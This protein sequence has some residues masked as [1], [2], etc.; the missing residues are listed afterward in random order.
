MSMVYLSQNDRI[1]YPKAAFHP[2]CAYPEYPFGGEAISK[3][4][5]VVYEAVRNCL[6]GLGY[7]SAN[8]GTAQ[9][10][11]LGELLQ[12]GQTVVIK[13]N[14]VMHENK[15]KNAG[16]HAMECLVTHPSCIR[17]ICDYCAIALKGTGNIIIADAPMQGCDFEVLK[18]KMHL[19]ELLDFYK[20]SKISVQLLDLREFQ[21][22]FDKN[23]VIVEKAYTESEGITVHLG[24]KSAHYR[25]GSNE[26]YQVS[27][28]EKD[29]TMQ[30]HHGAVHDYAISKTILQA[31]LLINFCKPKTHRLAGITAAMKNMVGAT[32]NKATLPHRCA[33]SRSEGGDAYLNKSWL[34][35][36]ADRALTAKIRAEAKH[37]IAKATLLRYVYGVFLV[38]GRKLAKDDYYIGSWY[39]NDTIWRTVVD[40]NY[41]VKYADKNG[42]L[43]D[44][45]QRKLLHF[46]DMIISGQ[47]N[48]PVSPEPKKLGIVL[49]SEDAAAFD[50]TVCK[51]M[52]FDADHIPLL[53]AIVQN[54]TWISHEK[55]KIYSNHKQYEGEVG[56]GIFPESWN[57]RPH[58][59]WKDAMKK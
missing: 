45:P 38:A 46:G 26:Q 53:R 47:R 35:R 13:P 2:D 59:A 11:P 19:N 17:A 8:Y 54:Q 44:T 33:G 51:I 28:Y 12:P 22:K 6:H 41:I 21:A 57:F 55:V 25:S 15:N 50:E 31:D 30:H 37:Q 4:P 29:E 48:G 56:D 49:A 1:Q 7:D 3:E 10:N 39:G 9:W 52:G 43:Q 24:E 40:L 5:N 36:M 16:E 20:N 58:D 18:E 32:Y 14:L 34:K 42:V 23:K 27:D